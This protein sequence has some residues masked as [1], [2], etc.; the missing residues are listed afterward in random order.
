MSSKNY[1]HFCGLKN[2]LKKKKF[3]KGTQA[4]GR[5]W[6]SFVSFSSWTWCLF[7]APLLPPPFPAQGLPDHSVGK[8][9]ACNAGD[10]G[11]ISELGRS[12]GEGI[13]Y[14]SSILGLPLWLSC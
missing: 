1:S 13:G 4:F 2:V 7:V 12:A 6:E 14:P 8:E 10:P 3:Q 11:L 9:S 5:K